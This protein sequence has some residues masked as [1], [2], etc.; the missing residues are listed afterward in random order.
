M[1]ILI[2]KKNSNKILEE[3]NLGKNFSRWEF[4]FKVFFT[5][6]CLLFS[7]LGSSRAPIR[8]SIMFFDDVLSLILS[9]INFSKI[10]KF[11]KAF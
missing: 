10:L 3:K 7:D 9:K 6:R 11:S 4:Y 5:P 1:L 2:E 8:F